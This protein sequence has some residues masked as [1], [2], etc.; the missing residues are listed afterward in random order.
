M[1]RCVNALGKLFAL[2]KVYSVPA[3]TGNLF[4][5]S[6]DRVCGLF[7]SDLARRGGKDF[8]AQLFAA[9]IIALEGNSYDRLANIFVFAVSNGVICSILKRFLFASLTMTEGF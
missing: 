8:K 1:L 7:N 6:L 4:P 9:A 3:Y 2:V 5:G